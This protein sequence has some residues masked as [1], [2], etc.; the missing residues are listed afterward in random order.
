MLDSLI[1]NLAPFVPNADGSAEG[2]YYVLVPVLTYAQMNV[3]NFVET[4]EGVGG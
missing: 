4:M 1:E 2:R 3:K